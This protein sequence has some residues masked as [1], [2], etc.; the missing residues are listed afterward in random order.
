[1]P[2]GMDRVENRPSLGSMNP[3]GS[4]STPKAPSPFFIVVGLLAIVAALAVLASYA[5]RWW[6]FADVLAN[7]RPQLGLIL[8][9]SF[10]ILLFGKWFRFAFLMLVIAAVDLLP[11]GL[12]YRPAASSPAT[13]GPNLRVVSF[14]LLSPNENYD[15]VI[16]FLEDTDADLVFLHE[17]SE[18]W[19]NAIT[20][21]T[22][23]YEVTRTRA[24]DQIFGTL[25]L[26][27]P[28]AEVSP[29]SFA[30]DGERAV[31]VV[32]PWGD[33]SISLLGI[34]PL[35]PSTSIRAGLRDDQLAFAAD[36]AAGQSGPVAVVGD[37]NASPWSHTFA[38]FREAGLLDSQQGFGVQLSFPTTSNLVLRVPIDHLLHSAELAV[39]D[40]RL[41]PSLGSDHN[42][43]IVDLAPAA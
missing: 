20:E 27:P 31:Q 36:W 41:G 19:E 15:E 37:F 12:L 33:A 28:G 38:A 18:P 16:T 4:R 8:L 23:S 24:D 7:F 1:M 25:V 10:V 35:S 42:P 9:A 13:F 2:A 6:W 26:A 21:S 30:F 22:L 43:L 34:H 17:A 14:N 39:V 32:L 29:F 5:G 11:V 40:R 3:P